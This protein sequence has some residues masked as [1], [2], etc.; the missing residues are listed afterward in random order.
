MGATIE[1][2]WK[3]RLDVEVMFEAIPD[4]DSSGVPAESLK[5]LCWNDLDR[6][7]VDFFWTAR[8]RDPRVYQRIL[9]NPRCSVDTLKREA[10]MS[11]EQVADICGVSGGAAWSYIRRQMVVHQIESDVIFFGEMLGKS[12]RRL[13]NYVFSGPNVGQ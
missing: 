13:H 1:D 4:A 9:A 5:L 6:M 10:G 7:F 8:L 12:A 2:E 11:A 3:E